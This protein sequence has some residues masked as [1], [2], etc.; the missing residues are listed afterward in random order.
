MST[1]SN[2]KEVNVYG[3]LVPNQD[4]RA[5]MASI[6]VDD[7]FGSAMA[8][9]AR[10]NDPEGYAKIQKVV[11]EANQQLELQRFKTKGRKPNASGG[12]A[13]MLGE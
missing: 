8:E 4:G 12:L 13:N 6:V 5:G 3:V 9:W 2:I 1:F 11:D 10:K 7:D